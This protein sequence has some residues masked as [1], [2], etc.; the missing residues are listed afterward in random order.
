MRVQENAV[1]DGIRLYVPNTG[2]GFVLVNITPIQKAWLQ[3]YGARAI[4]MDDTFNLITYCL[5]LATV[6]VADEWDKGLPAA[7]LL[8][9]QFV[10]YHLEYTRILYVFLE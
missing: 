4:I 1:D 2:E 7:Y 8:S 3:R 5:K 9:H 10:P 6:V